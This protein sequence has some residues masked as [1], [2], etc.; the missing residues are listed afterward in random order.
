MSYSQQ[1]RKICKS[2]IFWTLLNKIAYT[3][4]RILYVEKLYTE[5]IFKSMMVIQI[6]I[7]N[8]I[9]FYIKKCITIMVLF[10]YMISSFT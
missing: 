1:I 5:I 8:T 6:Q 10:I 9:W 4:R 3:N 7:F 2:K